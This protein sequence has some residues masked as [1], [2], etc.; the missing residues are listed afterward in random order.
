[1][2][3]GTDTGN[4]QLKV[5]LEE[6]EGAAAMLVAKATSEVT[7]TSTTKTTATAMLIAAMKRTTRTTAAAAAV[8]LTTVTAATAIDGAIDNNQLK[9]TAT[10][11]V[12]AVA[13]V[14]R[15]GLVAVAAATTGNGW[16][17]W[18]KAAARNE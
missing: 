16:R 1:M 9:V 3:V 6:V 18:L 17:K 4:N 10:E 7:S 12:A 8:V 13:N 11:M 15:G 2:V 14:G 5:A